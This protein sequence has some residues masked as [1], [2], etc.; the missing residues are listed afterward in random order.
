MLETEVYIWFW[1]P[2]NPNQYNVII[3]IFSLEWENFK[4]NDYLATSMAN[5]W[6]DRY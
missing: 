2:K 3:L 1:Y 6:Q 4:L 5:Q